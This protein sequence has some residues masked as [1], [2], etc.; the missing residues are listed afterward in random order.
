MKHTWNEFATVIVKGWLVLAAILQPRAPAATITLTDVGDS[1]PGTLRAA[2]ASVAAG[3][4]IVI[5]GGLSST[6]TLTSGELLV[7]RDVAI[8]GPGPGQMAV[9]GNH[10]SRVFHIGP[11]NIVSI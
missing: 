10:N 8:V 4:T 6:I 2:L 11:S 1:G 5:P 7:T 9:S 3:D